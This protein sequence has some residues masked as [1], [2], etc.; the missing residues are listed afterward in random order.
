[1]P[2]QLRGG[3]EL[4]DPV[5]LLEHGKIRQG[6]IIADLGCGAAGHFVFP[7]AHLVGPQGKVY[8]VDLLKSVLQAIDSRRKLEGVDNVD[9]IWAD[10]ERAGGMRIADSSVDL[11]LL[12][13]TLFQIKDKATIVREAARI[14]KS[15]G[16]LLVADWKMTQAPFGPPVEKR[17]DP[18]QVKSLIQS[19][20][21]ELVEEFEAGPYHY[22]LAFRKI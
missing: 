7:A 15:S 12:L 14:T 8:A 11:S 16:M 22:G 10:L 21:F 3:N 13:N 4:I 5:K 17:V 19:A 9:G 6:F 1:M 18:I 20:D 2:I